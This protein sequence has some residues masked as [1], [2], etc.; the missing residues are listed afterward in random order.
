MTNIE[1][2]GSMILIEEI[3]QEERK[4]NSGLVLAA[5]ALE[6]ELKRGKVIQVGPGDYDNL[7]NKH[8]IPL[9]FGDIVIYNESNATEVTDALGSKYYF[10]N[11]RHLFGKE[12]TF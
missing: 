8:E 1:P 11:W 7:G 3:K 6:N 9:T 4:T 10:I 12:G 2:F 5:T